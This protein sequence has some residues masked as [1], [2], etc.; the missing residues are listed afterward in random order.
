[1]DVVE[2]HKQPVT[3]D[4]RQPDIPENAPLAQGHTRDVADEVREQQIELKETVA[5]EAEALAS[6]GA[7]SAREPGD[8][9]GD[10][11][12]ADDTDPVPTGSIDDV[13]AWVGDDHDRAQRALEAERAGQQRTTLIGKL[14]A[15]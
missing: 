2:Y 1:M 8:H 10:V 13:L 15:L 12:T 14:E 6:D 7:V 5:A 9:A 3:L 11:E 4:P